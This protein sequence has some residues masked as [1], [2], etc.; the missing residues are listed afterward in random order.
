MQPRAGRGWSKK[1]GVH[2]RKLYPDLFCGKQRDKGD[3]HHCCR[4]AVVLHYQIKV[5]VPFDKTVI[6]IKLVKNKTGATALPPPWQRTRQLRA[7][8]PMA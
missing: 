5:G 3:T 1:S 7:T 4:K 8:A 6:R 2:P